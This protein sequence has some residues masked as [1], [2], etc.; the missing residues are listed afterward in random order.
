MTQKQLAH[1]TNDT[2]PAKKQSICSSTD[3]C[4]N[5]KQAAEIIGI[6]E[7]T[8]S[9]W[10]KKEQI[11]PDHRHGKR[12]YYTHDL[13][14]SYLA[15]YKVDNNLPDELETQDPIEK[16]AREPLSESSV[17]LTSADYESETLQPFKAEAK[18]LT[19]LIEGSVDNPNLLFLFLGMIITVTIKLLILLNSDSSMLLS[20]YQLQDHYLHEKN[21][22]SL[23]Y[24]PQGLPLVDDHQTDGK[25]ETEEQQEE[26]MTGSS[27]MTIWQ[28]A[29]ISANKAF[30]TLVRAV[31]DKRLDV[32]EQERARSLLT[33]TLGP[34]RRL[35]DYIAKYEPGT[36]RHDVPLLILTKKPKDFGIH[37]HRWSVRALEA[38]CIALKTKKASRATIG[39]IKQ[40][41]KW[42]FAIRP[43]LLSSDPEYGAIL[44]HIGLIL[45]KLGKDDMVIFN[46]DFKY[47][48]S[49]VAEYL[50]RK[51]LPA[52]M[53][54]IPPFA[55]HKTFYKTKAAIHL[56]GLL[57][58]KSRELLLQEL[59]DG[60]FDGYYKALTEL[61]D[62]L[63]ELR[64]NQGKI[65]L[66]I[67]NASN[68]QP[69][70]LRHLLLK[71]YNGSVEVLALPRYSP[72]QNL[73][74]RVWKFLLE[75]SERCG[76]SEDELWTYLEEA[77]Q[78][79]DDSRVE[80][81]LKMHCEICGKKW[82]FNEENREANEISLKKHLCFR[83][84]GLNPYI[85]YVL[86]HSLETLKQVDDPLGSQLA[87][88]D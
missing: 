41:L 49:K 5:A 28:K 32:E 33:E 55:I 50:K 15:L 43:K 37:S 70:V 17:I 60:T 73:I 76:N 79:Y 64:S 7:V 22:R 85:I 46:D 75:T 45:N 67:D 12:D 51:T 26:Q 39:R 36:A 29:V 38:A 71:K 16:L 62:E 4:Y 72:N 69:N 86:K 13:V 83:I 61:L 21:T 10:K 27:Q 24:S 77:K 80:R 30:M 82:I 35:T 25:P 19:S 44:L 40:E 52:G 8:F 47:T 68:H 48:S 9:N 54:T 59:E 88:I 63:I 3:D 81:E 23:Q 18:I 11:Q 6:S 34:Y 84:E 14:L 42:N 66:I 65:Y 20:A 31:N 74:E 53:N 1:S 57:C 56:T 87:L 2:P 78:K 58:G